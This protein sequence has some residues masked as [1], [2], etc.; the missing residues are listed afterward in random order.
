VFLGVTTD[1]SIGHRLDRLPQYFPIFASAK[2][3]A[4]SCANLF[5]ITLILRSVAGSFSRSWPTASAARSLDPKV[6]SGA[7]PRSRRHSVGEIF[8]AEKGLVSDQ[9]FWPKTREQQP[10]V[11]AVKRVWV[12]GR[13]AGARRSRRVP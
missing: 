4:S 5:R 2:L 1:R 8:H 12:G 9:P 11:D 10:I 6:P 3:S 7:F 13:S